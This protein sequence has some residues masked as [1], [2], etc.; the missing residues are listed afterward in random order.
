M[1]YALLLLVVSALFDNLPHE[2][3]AHRGPNAVSNALVRV[4][5]V[6]GEFPLW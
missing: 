5:E 6:N 1:L 2:H 3:S 4:V